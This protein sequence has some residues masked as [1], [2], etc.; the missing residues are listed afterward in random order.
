V[1]QANRRWS[2]TYRLVLGEDG[3]GCAQT[4]EFEASSAE[5]ALHLAGRECGGR[6]AELFESGRS[7]GR[8]RCVK[9]GG[10]WVI[11]PTAA[12]AKAG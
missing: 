5:A 3:Q 11:S 10:F 8:V 7:L 6:E 12:V 9:N 1:A 2:Q 4:L